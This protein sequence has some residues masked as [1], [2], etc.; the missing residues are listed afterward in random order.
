ME[1][2]IFIIIKIIKK[3]FIWI[4]AI[5]LFFIL[6]RTIRV[7]IINPYK[8]KTEIIEEY[9]NS[10][11]LLKRSDMRIGYSSGFLPIFDNRYWL[12][13]VNPKQFKNKLFDIKYNKYG[14]CLYGLH[15]LEYYPNIFY[16]SQVNY[17]ISNLINDKSKGNDFEKIEEIIDKKSKE[18]LNKGFYHSE[19][20]KNSKFRL[21]VEIIIAYK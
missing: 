5:I 10:N 3:I 21:A 6:I 8:I 13:I 18:I 15:E 17:V 14:T 11:V 1:K 19:Y 4:F 12:K 20:D 7:F 9:K 2:I 16:Y